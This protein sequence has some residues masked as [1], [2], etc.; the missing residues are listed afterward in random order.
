MAEKKQV[1]KSS[2]S[3][4]KSKSGSKNTKGKNSVAKKIITLVLT[5]ALIFVLY[6]YCPSA[7]QEYFPEV[8]QILGMPVEESSTASTSSTS[9]TGTQ[10]SGGTV[11]GVNPTGMLY[12]ARVNEP[13]HEYRDYLGYSLCYRESYEQAEWSADCLT[14]DKLKKVV[15][16]TDDFREDPGVSTGTATL[17]DYKGSGY[18]RGHLV[19]AANLWWDAQAMSESFYFSNMSP[20]AGAFNRG[21]WKELEEQVRDWAGE[22]G[23]VYI[24]SGPILEKDNYPTIG[25]KNKIAV[26]E[27]YYKVVLA[28]TDDDRWSAIGFIMANEKLEGEI[29]DY[30]TTVD[31]V[32]ARTNIDFFADLDDDVEAKLEST[33]DLSFWFK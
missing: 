32:E 25:K 3:S 2:T 21:M 31:A 12:P 19:P 8:A 5:L 11:T 22:F 18:D 7:L 26:P 30:V 33:Y 14:R 24:T 28:H 27:Y 10:K 20:Q 16:R 4:A 23:T 17:A 9:S 29:K 1:K 6:K 13:D 15:N